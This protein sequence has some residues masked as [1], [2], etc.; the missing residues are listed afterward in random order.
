MKKI[1]CVLACVYNYGTLLQSYATLKKIEALGYEC[2]V[3]RYRKKLSA[4]QKILMLARLIR[5]GEFSCQL[6]RLKRI[7]NKERYPSYWKNKTI[8]DTAFKQFVDERLKPYFREYSG[9]EALQA[10]SLNYN[11]VLVGSDQIWSLISLYGGYYNLMFVADQIPK[12][13]YASSFGV[14]AIPKFQQQAT[15][16]YLDRMQMIGV[17]EQ[18]GKNIVDA[19]SS[20]TATVVADPTMLLTPEEWEK[21]IEHISTERSRPYVFCYFLG[22]NQEHRRAVEALKEKTGYDI[23][24]VCHNDEYVK[25][26]EGFG[27]YVPYNVGPLEFLRYIHEADYVC[28]DSFHCTVFSILFKR[29]FLSFYRYGIGSKGSR[30]TRIDNLLSLL[31]LSDRIYKGDV[32]VIQSGI[33][34]QKV[35]EELAAYRGSSL[36]F[37]SQELSLAK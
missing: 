19:L 28:T 30:N 35:M 13:A 31:H 17:R 10:G 3:I 26:D 36:R 15:K 4:W 14:T 11:L 20:N 7:V 1:G 6:R 27:D 32:S 8:K 12:V 21:E 18:S 22:T 29:Q 9:Y 24:A 2:E 5:I 34:F 16:L 25:S 37:L 33:D 23:V